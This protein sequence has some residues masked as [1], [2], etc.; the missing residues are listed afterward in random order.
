MIWKCNFLQFNYLYTNI[1]TEK[2]F[3]RKSLQNEN[4]II[5]KVII[6]YLFERNFEEIPTI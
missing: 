5:S 2:M 6:N 4:V 1:C 3:Y